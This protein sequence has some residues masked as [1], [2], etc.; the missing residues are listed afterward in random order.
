MSLS[1]QRVAS[2]AVVVLGAGGLLYAEFSGGSG[3]PATAVAQPQTPAQLSAQQN[4]R[5]AA[6]QSRYQVALAGMLRTYAST[7]GINPLEV[8]DPF[9]TPA[10]WSPVVSTP[11]VPQDA[12]ESPIR[13][14]TAPMTLTAL[15]DGPTGAVARVN[16]VLL[17]VGKPAMVPGVGVIELVEVGEDRRSA[18]IRSEHGVTLLQLQVVMAPGGA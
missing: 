3:G 1:S 10:S 15:L 6:D 13:Q 4:T 17:V 14:A 16:G 12:A 2:I 18:L 7:Q 11:V 9:I 5:E 8:A